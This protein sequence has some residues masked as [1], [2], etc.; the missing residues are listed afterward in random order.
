VG[1]P[2]RCAA[3]TPPACA[4][5]QDVAMVSILAPSAAKVAAAGSCELPF[6]EARAMAAANADVADTNSD[7]DDTVTDATALAAASGAAPAPGDS[8]LA[9]ALAE[10]SCFVRSLPNSCFEAAPP[11]PHPGYTLAQRAAAAAWTAALY[12][13]LGLVCGGAGQARASGTRTFPLKATLFSHT[14]AR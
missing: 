3:L 12:G 13:V 11:A 7:A 8:G 5:R 4:L 14:H 9:A 2:A 1:A 10:A 6:I